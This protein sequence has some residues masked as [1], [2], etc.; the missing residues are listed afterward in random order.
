M[1]RHSLG[2]LTLVSLLPA[3]SDPLIGTAE[4]REELFHQIYIKT[5]AREAFSKIKNEKL[6]LDLGAAMRACRE[7]MVNAK[8]VNEFLQALV[9]LSCSRRDRHL[10]VDLVEGGLLPDQS[11][12]WGDAPLRFAVDY[13]MEGEW[14][15]FV[16]E[17]AA[18]F[19]SDAVQVGDRVIGVHGMSFAN[20]SQAI[21]PYLRSSTDDV[22]WR[23]YA[24]AMAQRSWRWPAELNPPK[25]S[26][27]LRRASGESYSISADWV[28]DAEELSW[29]E[30][31]PYPKAFELVLDVQTYD[32]YKHSSKPVLVLD[33]YGF[34]EDLVKDMD[35][36]MAMAEE[37]GW[38]THGIIFDGTRSRGGSRGAYAVQRLFGRPFK[39]T[40]GNLRLSDVVP[41]FIE[42]V[43]KRRG[44][45]MD[46]GVAE[47]MDEGHWLLDW[48]EDDVTKGMD[49]GQNYSNN[50]PFKLAHLPKYSDGIIQP[51]GRHFRGPVVCLFSPHGG[52]HLD[53]FASIVV[54]NGLAHTMGMPAGGYS[55]TW[56]WEETLYLPTSEKPLVQFMWSIGHT[57]R[58]NG[59]V[60]EGNPA[61]MDEFVP[62]TRKNYVGYRGMLVER[63]MER[64]GR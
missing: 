15:C 46:A 2:L 22:L 61:L 40:F 1:F 19:E 8:T 24:N 47:S 30:A 59:E 34:R 6:G 16:A 17:I 53:Q 29:Q 62:V 23:E 12:T 9:K 50:V 43:R 52:S 28:K 11:E 57:I 3:Q 25:A 13:G 58:P 18:E 42:G 60:L 49:R 39:T 36:L 48:L 32:L 27:M 20:W 54:D 55:N 4:Q 14:T 5:M 64:L 41:E 63:A 37:R 35:Q 33:W 21:A 31:S 38:L 56:E 10:S 51:A 7:D 44:R 45:V 26:Y